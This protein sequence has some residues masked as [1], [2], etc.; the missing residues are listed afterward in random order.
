MSCD[1]N[2]TLDARQAEVSEGGAHNVGAPRLSHSLH[3]ALVTSRSLPSICRPNERCRGFRKAWTHGLGRGFFYEP[4]THVSNPEGITARIMT[5]A[6]AKMIDAV[7]EL[8]VLASGA[9]F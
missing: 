9:K 6:G 2:A 3:P 8:E 1:Q 7:Q 5:S 4:E